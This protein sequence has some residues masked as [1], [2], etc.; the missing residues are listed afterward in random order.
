MQT[1]SK[2]E[3][4]CSATAITEL[5][6][7]GKQ[8]F[9]HPVKLLWLQ[10]E[11]TEGP[12][13]KVIISVSKRNFKRAVDR[14]KIKRI[15]R[16]CYRKNKHI[17]ES[18]LIGKKFHMGLIYVGKQIPEYNTIEPIIIGLLQRLTVDHEKTSG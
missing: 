4:L 6:S 15:L 11:S 13:I 1:F 8:I 16:E 5:F 18:V 12:C 14:N 9:K 3:K 2:D 10:S 7:K 17:V